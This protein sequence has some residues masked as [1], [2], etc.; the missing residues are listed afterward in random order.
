M[1]FMNVIF[2]LV[3]TLI[4]SSC[5]MFKSNTNQGAGTGVGNPN[6]NLS[7]Q[8]SA[9]FQTENKN[10]EAFARAAALTPGWPDA[11]SQAAKDLIAKYGDPQE[12]TSDMLIWRN[13]AP[14]K[15]IVVH[16]Q[17]YSSHFPLLHQ[18]AVEHT[19]DYKAPVE[20]IDDVWRFDGSIVLNR[21]RGEMSA[22]GQNEPMNILAFNLA[23]KVLRGQMGSEAARVTYGKEYLNYM[24]G[25]RNANTSVL[26]FGT[27]YQTPDI[28]K[29]VTSKIR[30][31]GDPNA[32]KTTQGT[33]S[34]VQDKQQAQQAR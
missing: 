16:K 7:Q 21:N 27:Q 4:A 33:G 2:V 1:K 31:I 20:K 26:N 8:Q 18:N 34:G 12:T 3:T 32:K 17:I 6:A 5:S 19:V 28:D 22:F 9:A 14:F 25:K 23:D 13:V 11:S 10:K 29:S 30:W 15:K 24:D